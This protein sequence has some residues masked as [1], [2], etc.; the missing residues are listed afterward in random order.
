MNQA[1]I[2]TTAK[3]RPAG[4]ASAGRSSVLGEFRS[5]PF[6]VLRVPIDVGVDQAIWKAE[7]VLTR[8]RAGLPAADA[9]LLP[10]L[11]E[12]DETETR[13]AVQRVEEPL[14]RLTDQMFW[15]DPERD[16]DGD[17]L[18][19]GLISLEPTPLND[20]LARCEDDGLPRRAT[21]EQVR[22][23]ILA[24]MAGRSSR[25]TASRRRTPRPGPTVRLRRTS[26][27][28]PRPA[29]CRG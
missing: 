23:R 2:E 17:L 20:Y 28:I 27:R 15:F 9:D 19:Q 25:R 13:Q 24:D 3:G 16:P 1:A 12:P 21:S 4:L 22:D 14:R 18:R 5:N 11:P 29:R 8:L 6:R 7:E 26:R 10:W